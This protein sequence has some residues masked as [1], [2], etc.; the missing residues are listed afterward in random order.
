MLNARFVDVRRATYQ[1]IT[2]SQ[3]QRGSAAA[4]RYRRAGTG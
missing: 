1:K 2:G 4:P 3:G